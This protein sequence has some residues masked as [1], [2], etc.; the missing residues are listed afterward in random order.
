MDLSPKSERDIKARRPSR[1]KTWRR[2]INIARAYLC[3]RVFAVDQGRAS[4]PCGV[5]VSKYIT[6]SLDVLYWCVWSLVM[7]GWLE[8]AG[9]EK[10][11]AS[12]LCLSFYEFYLSI[13]FLFREK[14]SLLFF[15]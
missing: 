6:E 13:Y 1:R 14:L 3:A 5:I 7:R 12:G 8:D 2:P 9:D 10:K 4:Y 11:V 15:S